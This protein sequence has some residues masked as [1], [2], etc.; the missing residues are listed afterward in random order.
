MNRW[1]LI[2]VAG[3]VL[4]IHLPAAADPAGSAATAAAR[5]STMRL[6]G[7]VTQF[8]GKFYLEDTAARKKFEL[9]GN[10]LNKYVG[11]SV[12]ARGVLDAADKSV[13]HVSSISVASGTAAPAAKTGVQ[14]KA[15]VI[16]GAAAAAA[17]GASI[18]VTRD[19]GSKTPVSPTQP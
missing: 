6:A 15:I 2:V 4:A 7:T 19:S 9:Q 10:N 1:K 16:G 13:V 18:A 8:D 14:T 5:S 3:V 11:K 12:R 17:T